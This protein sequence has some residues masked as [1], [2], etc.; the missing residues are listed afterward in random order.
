MACNNNVPKSVTG[1]VPYEDAFETRSPD[2][3]HLRPFRCRFLYHPVKPTLKTFKS[4]L[5]EGIN[6]GNEDGG[7]YSLLTETG[8]AR[9]KHVRMLETDFPGIAPTLEDKEK[10]AIEKD[11]EAEEVETDA[12]S[13]ILGNTSSGSS[14][15]GGEE[16]PETD[17]LFTYPPVQPSTFG[18]TNDNQEYDPDPNSDGNADEDITPEQSTSEDDFVDELDDDDE[19]DEDDDGDDAPAPASRR[20][21]LRPRKDINYVYRAVPA[22]L[23]NDKP[24]LKDALNSPD[25]AEWVK[26]IQE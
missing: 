13:V 9:K 5:E 25:K 8:F 19:E 22:N 1:R 4:R 2:L 3:A 21:W 23:I 11:L 26:Y 6:L 15:S 10:Q 20:P 17:A 16:P 24:K 18:E 7:I 14:Q 12:S